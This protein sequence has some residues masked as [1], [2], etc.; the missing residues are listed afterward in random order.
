M[1]NLFRGVVA[2]AFAGSFVTALP[3]ATITFSRGGVTCPAANSGLCTAVAGATTITFDE[4]SSA[5]DAPYQAGI[6][7]FTW[8][9]ASP[10]VQGSAEGLY[11]AP[12]LN[13]LL[14]TTTYLTV[15]SGGSMPNTVTISFSKPISYFGFY[16]GSPDTYNQISFFDEGVLIKSFTGDQLINPGNG[17]QT[18]ADY[19]NFY[20]HGAVITRIV[21]TSLTPAFENDSHSYQEAPE[22]A[23][24]A[25]AAGFA[26][27]LLCWAAWRRRTTPVALA[28][29]L[30]RR[31]EESSRAIRI[32]LF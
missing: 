24:G 11:A 14:D 18:L 4:L 13:A 2:V 7:T 10:F 30:R 3:G 23:T 31:A 21:M 6:A 32:G 15:G 9:G 29:R 26:A 16:L 1:G 27:F 25:L 28:S 8:T 19:V 20:S 22:P 12:T 5:T 17:S